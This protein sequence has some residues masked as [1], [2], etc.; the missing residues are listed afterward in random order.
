M[1]LTHPQSIPELP[2]RLRIRSQA[3]VLAS[4]P[5]LCVRIFRYIR[6]VQILPIGPRVALFDH[7]AVNVSA[8]KIDDSHHAGITVDVHDDHLDLL[9]QH[10]LRQSLLSLSTVGLSRLGHNPCSTVHLFSLWSVYSIEANLELAIFWRRYMDGV[11]IDDPRDDTLL[12]ADGL[13]G[14]DQER[15]QDR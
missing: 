11:S 8:V 4:S 12:G 2:R 14:E 7:L 6:P 10:F 3:E 9:V 5:L 1:L 15:Q 13:F